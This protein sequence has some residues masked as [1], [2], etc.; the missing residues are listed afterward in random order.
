MVG[1]WTIQFSPLTYST[2]TKALINYFHSLPRF[3]NSNHVELLVSHNNHERWKYIKGVISFPILM[4]VI[5]VLWAKCTYILRFMGIGKCGCAAGQYTFKNEYHLERVK[6][7]Q[8]Y[9]RL[10]FTLFSGLLIIVSTTLVQL[11]LPKLNVSLLLI[12][13][14][15]E[16]SMSTIQSMIYI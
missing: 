6:I 1:T 10:C 15:V 4:L 16:V 12:T 7:Y 2:V 8:K 13:G 3:G 14:I 11:A 9:T 5:F